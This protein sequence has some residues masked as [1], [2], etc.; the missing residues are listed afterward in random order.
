VK[1]EGATGLTGRLRAAWD[2]YW[3][4]PGSLRRLACCRILF[5]GFFI[6]YHHADEGGGLTSFIG[7]DVYAPMLITR[8]LH[9]V[10][11]LPYLTPAV[12]HSLYLLM[13]VFAALCLLGYRTGLATTLTAILFTYLKAEQYSHGGYVHHPSAIVALSVWALALSPCGAVLSLD[14]LRGRRKREVAAESSVANE[15]HDPRS[16]FATWPV[17]FI[18]LF[19]AIAYF[20]AG[21]CKIWLGDGLGWLNGD[22][23]RYYL[24]QGGMELGMRLSD[25]HLLTQLMSIVTLLFELSFWLVLVFPSLTWIYAL[26]GLGF[27]IGSYYLMNVWFIPFLL[28]YVF[29]FDWV[30]LETKLRRRFGRGRSER[31]ED[32]RR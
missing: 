6:I 22:T 11:G 20:L 29:L 3:F 4:R 18:P 19:L 30:A 32:S 24:V 21:A 2:T 16:P 31:A 17:R 13:I 14:A 27:H 9:D 1:G 25:H 10:L 28:A 7:T 15:G 26:Y 8:V 5:F 12:Q 23:L